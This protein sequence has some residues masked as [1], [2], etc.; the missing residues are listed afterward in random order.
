MSSNAMIIAFK[1]VSCVFAI[2]HFQLNADIPAI[3]LFGSEGSGARTEKWIED[4][5]T[6]FRETLNEWFDNFNGFL[7]WVYGVAG[8]VPILNVIDGIQW[9]SRI[10]LCENKSCFMPVIKKTR[11]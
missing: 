11:S 1:L 6:G 9:F 5:L 3:S 4:H 2:F 8:I 10:T 7:S